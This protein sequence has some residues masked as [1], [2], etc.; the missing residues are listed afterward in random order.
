MAKKDNPENI[1][2]PELESIEDDELDEVAG[3]RGFIVGNE[4]VIGSDNKLLNK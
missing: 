2:N 4:T 3:G 1:A